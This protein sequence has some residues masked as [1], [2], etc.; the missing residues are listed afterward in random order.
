MKGKFGFFIFGLFVGAVLT[1]LAFIIYS[2]GINRVMETVGIDSS[3]TTTE[4]RNQIDGLTLFDSEGATIPAVQLR[5]FQTLGSNYALAEI[6]NE[7]LYDTVLYGKSVA[8][9][10][11][12]DGEYSI[13]DDLRI[14][15]TGGKTIVQIGTYRYQT[16]DQNWK[17]V[18]VVKIK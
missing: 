12:N 7:K 14:D 2:V 3:N 1:A 17:T 16:V 8:A 15:I 13:Y 6:S 5:V 11:V 10:L 18:P 9:L 4:A